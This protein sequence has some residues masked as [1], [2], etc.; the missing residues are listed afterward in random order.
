VMERD[1]HVET[2]GDLESSVDTYFHIEMQ[3]LLMGSSGSATS[4]SREVGRTHIHTASCLKTNSWELGGK[5]PK[6]ENSTPT[7]KYETTFRVKEMN[8]SLSSGS[9]RARPVG[10][11]S[12]VRPIWT[13]LP[14]LKPKKSTV[15]E[16]QYFEDS[17]RHKDERNRVHLHDLDEPVLASDSDSGWVDSWSDSEDVL[18]RSGLPKKGAYLMDRIESQSRKLEAT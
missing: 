3:I 16:T 7:R 5:S 2:V 4:R 10:S 6:V 1:Q 12:R 18:S 8:G 17:D 9:D 15:Q 13:L 11:R 14:P